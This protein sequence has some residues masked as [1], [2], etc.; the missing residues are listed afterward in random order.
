MQTKRTYR[1]LRK[2]LA[3]FAGGLSQ[4][5]ACSRAG[6]SKE[7]YRRWKNDEER[8][9]LLQERAETRYISDE[10]GFIRREGKPSERLALL[11]AR[12]PEEY[13]DKRTVT[14]EIVLEMPGLLG[15]GKTQA[16]AN[17]MDADWEAID[18]R[19]ASGSLTDEDREL[20]GLPTDEDA[21]GDSPA[22]DS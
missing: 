14:H 10:T 21:D 8:V 13:G 19:A 22:S 6:V 18:E 15:G 4:N 5:R 9:G 7:F 17:L 16:Q 11:K 1:I 2:I 20:I 3:G 12:F